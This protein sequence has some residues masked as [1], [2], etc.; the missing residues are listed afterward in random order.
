MIQK[1]GSLDHCSPP[2]SKS[3]YMLFLLPRMPDSLVYLVN[4]A[5][6]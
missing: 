6:P 3:L 2:I 1:L 4:I 5:Q